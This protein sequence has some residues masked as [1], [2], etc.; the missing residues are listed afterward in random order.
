MVPAGRVA[1]RRRATSRSRPPLS[2]AGKRA[3][4]R[5]GGSDLRG[6]AVVR[7]PGTQDVGEELLLQLHHVPGHVEPRGDDL[8]HVG[9]PPNASPGLDVAALTRSVTCSTVRCTPPG[10]RRGSRPSPSSPR[11]PCHCSPRSVPLL[12]VALLVA[13]GPLELRSSRSSARSLAV[14]GAVLAALILLATRPLL[15]LLV[16]G[17][18]LGPLVPLPCGHPACCRRRG[19]DRPPP[20]PRFAAQILLPRPCPLRVG[21]LPPVRRVAVDGCFAA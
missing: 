7:V 9:R 3:S 18:P 19:R 5:G 10:S 4:G 15:A 13:G 20:V 17:I 1:P 6:V 2:H 21:W 14:I 11:S 16:A 12:P 8:R